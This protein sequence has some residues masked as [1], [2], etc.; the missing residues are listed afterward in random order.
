LPG[1]WMLWANLRA[2][3]RSAPSC[4]Q[5]IGSQIAVSLRSWANSRRSMRN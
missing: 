5:A 3:P 4:P 1:L 2:A